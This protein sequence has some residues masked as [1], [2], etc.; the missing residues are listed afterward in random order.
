MKI[1]KGGT[2][3]QLPLFGIDSISFGMTEQPVL[4]IH[5]VAGDRQ[6]VFISAIDSVTHIV[7]AGADTG[8]GGLIQVAVAGQV[9]DEDGNPVA[10]AQVQAGNMSVQTDNNGIFYI[11]NAEMLER[12]GY[13]SVFKAGYFNGSRTFLPTEGTNRAE[14][15]LLRKNVAG[16]V[17]A[18]TGGT[19]QLEG[20]SISF[21]GGSFMQNGSPYT[22]PVHVTL[23]YLDPESEYFDSE[24]PGMLLGRMGDANWFLASYGMVAVELIGSNGNKVE[25]ASGFT[26]QV[27]FPLSA[28]LQADAP[29]HIDLWHFDESKGYWLYEGRA[30][31][32]GDAY[33]ADVTHFSFWSLDMPWP[34][35]RLDGQVTDPAG[36]TIAGARVSM[37]SGLWGGSATAYSGSSGYFGGY[38]PLG[39][40]LT[41][42][43]VMRCR[44]YFYQVYEAETG[45][46]SDST[47]L[48]PIRIVVPAALNRV[49]GTITDC[50][51]NPI[52][53]GYVVANGQVYSSAANGVFFL[54]TCD[55]DSIT[56]S[57]YNA[58]PWRAGTS[59]T[60]ALNGDSVN[61]GVLQVCATPVG[62]G[63]IT[64]V[65]DI[66]GN[67]YPVVQIGSQCWMQENL[68]TVRYADGSE[69]PNVTNNTAWPGLNSGAW[70]YYDN[71]SSYNTVYGKLYNGYVVTD[72]RNVCPVG[73]HVPTDDEW[74]TLEMYLGM[75]VAEAN[76]AN[77]IRGLFANVGGKL[78]AT[79]GWADRSYGHGNGT[80]TSGF[81]ALPGAGRD[82]NSAFGYI[83]ETGH[84]WSSSESSPGYVWFR[85]LDYN[86]DWIYRIE[87]DKGKGFS[88]R[89]M[90]D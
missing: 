58:S 22:G 74:K 20:M 67:T 78:K 16:T 64:M 50:D 30:V 43:V 35:I 17:Q 55:S 48:P 42:R 80:N 3:T 39:D 33:V 73:W 27:R 71:N 54:L 69:I 86:F 85:A 57:S 5:H 7:P 10:D 44:A 60:F 32:Q 24:M 59:V 52:S 65:T 56:I 63:D 70:C 46:F 26:A 79:S 75:S 31:R 21:I 12:L 66:D 36:N 90:R 37:H 13:I 40:T 2:T 87:A 72:P 25:L 81:T 89:C 8:W 18:V 82:S 28:T 76:E 11:S 83:G 62:C 15:R 53:S 51:N 41:V 14:I 9:F 49:T 68:R 29:A 4:H 38:V 1:H 88:V 47:V 77:G 19:V 84:W 23:N 61:V 6:S 34:L 45:P